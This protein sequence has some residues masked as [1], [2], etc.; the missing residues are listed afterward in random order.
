MFYYTNKVS[1]FSKEVNKNL[2]NENPDQA[3]ALVEWGAAM[4]RDGIVKGVVAMTT[5]TIVGNCLVNIIYGYI[6]GRKDA[7]KLFNKKES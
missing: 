2:A 1:D 3:N 4:H 6:K 7:K 5:V